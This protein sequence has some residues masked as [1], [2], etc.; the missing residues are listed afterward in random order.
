MPKSYQNK[1]GRGIPDRWLDYKAVGKRLEGTRFIAFKVPL[2]PSLTYHLRPTDVFGPWELLDA[3]NEDHGTLG[4]I[5]DLTFT[6]RY[7]NLR[8]LPT[9]LLHE[10]IFTAGREVPNDAT[11]LDFKRAVRRFLRVNKGN[12]KLIGVHCTHGLNRTGYL[13]CRYLIDVDGM[14]PKQAVDLFN[15]S[16]GHNIEREEYLDDLQ[17]GPKRSNAGME[18]LKQEPLRG[19]ARQRPGSVDDDGAHGSFRSHPQS[20]QGGLLPTPALLPSPPVRQ[21]RASFHPYR[22]QAAR[23]EAQWTR[24]APPAPYAPYAASPPPLPSSCPPA[25]FA[26]NPSNQGWSRGWPPSYNSSDKPEDEW[27]RPYQRRH[28][29]Y[30]ENRHNYY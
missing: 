18:E 10:K 30:R 21:H 28:H 29:S 4:L 15:S 23:S 22:W 7:Y 2:K 12:D 3:V 8:D 26:S 16:R 17:N 27:T 6:S 20:S 1:G 9:S 14:D 24:P 5:I 11:I 13:I 25:L 19:L